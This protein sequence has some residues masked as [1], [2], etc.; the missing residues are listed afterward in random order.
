MTVR[1]LYSHEVPLTLSSRTLLV[2]Y[3]VRQVERSLLRYS[4]SSSI[5]APSKIIRTATRPMTS[6]T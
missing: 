5:V 6:R 2:A 1:S 4:A 3:A